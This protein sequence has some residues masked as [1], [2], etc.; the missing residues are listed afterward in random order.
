MPKTKAAQKRSKLP[1]GF[2]HEDVPNPYGNNTDR[3]IRR[4]S[5]DP[6]LYLYKRKSITEAEYQA[7]CK[8]QHAH[9]VCQGSDGGAIDYSVDR[10]DTS[11]ITQPLQDYQIAA[12]DTIAQATMALDFESL[13]RVEK[14]AGDGLSIKDYCKA[15]HRKSYN[16]FLLQQSDLLKENLCELAIIWGYER[17]NGRKHVA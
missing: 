8:F 15:I 7:A 4:V 3:V 2:I 1:Q 9:T 11:G 14:I 16:N 13:L 6:I 10:V 5:N 12:M 17:R